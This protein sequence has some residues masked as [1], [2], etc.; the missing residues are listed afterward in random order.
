MKAVQWWCRG[1][2]V[3]M[4]CWLAPSPARA[5]RLP[6]GVTPE[7]Y[8]LTIT[9]DL[10]AATFK[11][12]ET[13]DVTVANETDSITLNA[14]D[15]RFIS[16]L[17]EPEKTPGGSVC[18]SATG[19]APD[20][21][22]VTLQPDTQQAT[23]AFRCA[24]APG[25]V[26]LSIEYTGILNN[27]LRGFY[28]SKTRTRSYGVTQFEATDARRAFPS[29]DEPALKATFDVTLVVDA[30]DTAI[31]NT[32]IVSDTPGP[33]AAKHTIRF[34]TTP[35][36]STY[37]VAWLIGDW[38]CSE[39]KSEGV[40]I[41]VCATPDKVGL[42][43]FALEVA[44]W[45]LKYFDRYFGIRYPMAKM[46]LV[47]IPDFEAGAME[48]FGC[49]TFRETELLVDEKTGTVPSRKEVATTVAHEISHQW[50]GDMVTMDWWDNL[51]LNEGFATWMEAKAAAQWRADWKFDQDVAVELDGTM[52]LDAQPTTRAIRTR[53]ETPEEIDEMFDGIAYGKAG[54]VID[55]VENWVGEET[56]RRGV[57][58]YLRAHLYGNA[59][60]EDFWGTLTRVSGQP[61]DAVMRSF[62]DQPGVPVISLAEADA[63]RLAVS[64][65]RFL[66]SD[67]LTRPSASASSSAQSLPEALGA[68]PS[69]TVPVCFRAAGCT[70]I[71]PA[72][73]S[74]P[75]PIGRGLLFANAEDK[76]YY[77]TVYS[78]GQIAAINAGVE[79]ELTP[80]ERIG[81]L[82]DRW[83]L[84]RAGTG[85]V[86]DYLDLVLAVKS[87]PNATVL[88]NALGRVEQL[89]DMV[90][91]ESDRDRLNQ[92][93]RRELTPIYS[94]LGPGSKHDDWERADLR[95]TLYEA[96]GAAGDPEVLA[97]A[98]QQ[99]TALLDGKKPHDS[100]IA[101]VSVAL[102]ARH[103]DTAMYEKV[104]LVAGNSTDPS[105]KT[106]ALHLLTRFDDPLLVMRTLE[107]ALSDAVR[108]QDS[109]S[110]IVLELGRRETQ[111]LAWQF[112][113]QHWAEIAG[114]MTVN[115]GGK[116]AEAAG[117]FCS[118]A[119]RSEV[120]EFFTNHPVAPQR[121][122]QKSLESIE[123]C[124]HLKEVQEPKLRL[125]LDAHAAPP[126]R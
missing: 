100:S 3:A 123:G 32:P 87:D 27:K 80:P 91:S 23:F 20:S 102:A 41:R 63:G 4:L 96:L 94:A 74:V 7:H 113:V 58:Q 19:D 114:K 45:D 22:T 75:A 17:A 38:A 116:I 49:L 48:N 54:S 101:D 118:A 72:T 47:A 18:A 79:R 120:E 117:A 1:I 99:A 65:S 126:V 30:G 98:S 77:R 92:V 108:S 115:G 56:F 31:S 6:T 34:A 69:W 62:V 111:D 105:L 28:L 64:Q 21:A 78:P 104:L 119:K 61:V 121:T 89:E 8:S 50:F 10:K 103:G 57:Q 68:S 107:Y 14:L 109:W 51:W 110:V 76:G 106:D 66:L 11:G 71:Q 73:S 124:V 25:K 84:M 16:V 43:K 93:I 52:D 24:M 15:L 53:A 9:P 85:S 2:A 81:L 39:G 44:R 33:L 5:Q 122:V 29:F 88:D 59:T 40:P 97:D 37:L 125:W 26:R 46:D 90:A 67:E 95:S 12:V 112:V 70:V 35:R 36:M 83:A 42:T 55:M 60:A 82:S 13:I 86:G